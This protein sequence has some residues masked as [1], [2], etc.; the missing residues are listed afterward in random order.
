MT[1]TQRKIK[2][3][4]TNGQNRKICFSVKHQVLEDHKSWEKS[5]SEVKVNIYKKNKELT[6]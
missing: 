5:T 4:F 6:E 3:L 2:C 1:E